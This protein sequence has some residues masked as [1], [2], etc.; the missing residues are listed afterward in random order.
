L[1]PDDVAPGTAE[2]AVL[3]TDGSIS[4]T[5]GIVSDVAPGLLSASADGRGPAKAQVLQRLADGSTRTLETSQCSGYVCRTLPIP[6]SPG[7]VTT[8]RLEGTGFRH[9]RSKADFEVTVAEVSVPVISFGAVPGI[10]GND[11]L[12]VRL[13]ADLIGYGETDLFVKVSGALSN[14]V[15]IHCGGSR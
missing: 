7:I 9:A 11:R 15:R 8:L 5:K 1:I 13:P 10:P 14:V 12:T 6:L 3:R 4:T 2:F